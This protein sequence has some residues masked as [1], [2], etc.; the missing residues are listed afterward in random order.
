MR[1]VLL[2]VTGA[3]IGAL[4]VCYYLFQELREMGKVISGE[5]Y[6]PYK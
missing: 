6:A 5:K 1:V 2:V 3:I 4:G